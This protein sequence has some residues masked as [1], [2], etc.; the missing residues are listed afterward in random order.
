MGLRKILP[1]AYPYPVPPPYPSSRSL[2]SGQR[3]SARREKRGDGQGVEGRASAARDL[4]GK[5]RGAECLRSEPSLYPVRVR[6]STDLVTAFPGV[7]SPK[8]R[9][10]LPQSLTVHDLA[11][12]ASPTHPRPTPSA[13]AEPPHGPGP[14]R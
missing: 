8:A 13:A 6:R 3:R 7:D 9:R 2:S 11:G 12:T 10:T 5:R 1:R 4:V 14:I